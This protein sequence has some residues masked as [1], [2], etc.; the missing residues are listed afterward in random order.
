MQLTHEQQYGTEIEITSPSDELGPLA[1]LTLSVGLPCTYQ[2]DSRISPIEAAHRAAAHWQV[3]LLAPKEATSPVFPLE[4]GPLRTFNGHPHICTSTEAFRL[5]EEAWPLYSDWFSP[6]SNS[7]SQTNF[8]GPPENA[9]PV[10]ALYCVQPKFAS[11]MRVLARYGL[12]TYWLPD[13]ADLISFFACTVAPFYRVVDAAEKA[14]IEGSILRNWLH[15][16][17][18]SPP[19]CAGTQ[20]LFF[21]SNVKYFNAYSQYQQT[22]KALRAAKKRQEENPTLANEILI[23][24]CERDVADKKLAFQKA[25]ATQNVFPWT[26]DLA[27][28][29]PGGREVE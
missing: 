16:G 10:S 13:P 7:G 6:D 22:Q 4:T 25:K 23:T 21:F 26:G 8:S 15:R 20:P 11:S 29:S 27:K 5:G 3:Q 14:A 19:V 18:F 1:T 2:L 12:Q 24:E 28:N 9:S 17:T